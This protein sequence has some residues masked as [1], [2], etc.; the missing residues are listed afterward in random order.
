MNASTGLSTVPSL[1]LRGINLSLQARDIVCCSYNNCLIRRQSDAIT[2]RQ[3]SERDREGEDV[4]ISSSTKL[5]SQNLLGIS[6]LRPE[7]ASE[8]RRL[9][10][11]RKDRVRKNTLQN[12]YNAL[13]AEVGPE[14]AAVIAA[15]KNINFTDMYRKA[16]ALRISHLVSVMEGYESTKKMKSICEFMFKSIERRSRRSSVPELTLSAERAIIKKSK[17]KAKDEKITSKGVRKSSQFVPLGQALGMIDVD[18]AMPKNSL[19]IDRLFYRICKTS[20]FLNKEE[21]VH[22]GRKLRVL[23]TESGAKRLDTLADPHNI[24]QLTYDEAS[25]LVLVANHLH[26]LFA[27]SKIKGPRKSAEERDIAL[28][29]RFKDLHVSPLLGTPPHSPPEVEGEQKNVKKERR[30]TRSSILPMGVPKGVIDKPKKR[31]SSPVDITYRKKEEV[32]AVLGSSI[33]R[34]PLDDETDF[35]PPVIIVDEDPDA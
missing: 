24:M 23:S 20:S 1:S 8:A 4:Q 15:W 26:R 31:K 7:I 6:Y 12:Y 18:E 28:V 27:E 11:A 35:L 30:S 22:I 33:R 19:K 13:T 10:G 3:V 5:V 34:N 2:V 25:K 9:T 14:F 32:G 16:K 21:M 29:E 17:K